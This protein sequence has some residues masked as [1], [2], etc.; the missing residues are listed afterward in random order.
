[1]PTPGVVTC[2][3]ETLRGGYSAEWSRESAY[4]LRALL[5]SNAVE[6]EVQPEAEQT[7]LHSTANKELDNP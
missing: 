4:R 5:D 6:I 2:E 1:M 7:V 3:T